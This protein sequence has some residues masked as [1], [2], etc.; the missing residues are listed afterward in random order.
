MTY[1]HNDDSSDWFI[2]LLCHQAR[3][4]QCKVTVGSLEKQLEEE[5]LKVQ[6]AESQRGAGTG[7][8]QWALRGVYELQTTR[9]TK[10]FMCCFSGGHRTSHSS[11][12]ARGYTRAACSVETNKQ[13]H[14]HNSPLFW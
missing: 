8:H 4:D 13:W 11:A 2:I 1:S 5:K 12:V 6:A 3:L 9:Q 14:T 10:S 7:K